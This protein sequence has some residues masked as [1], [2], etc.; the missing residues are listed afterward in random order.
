MVGRIFKQQAALGGFRPGKISFLV[1]NIEF[2]FV[3]AMDVIVSPAG[4]EN[5]L[6]TSVFTSPAVS[7]EEVLWSG[8]EFAMMVALNSKLLKEH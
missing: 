8:L 2:H 5:D 6:R 4:V 3:L 1:M 7:E